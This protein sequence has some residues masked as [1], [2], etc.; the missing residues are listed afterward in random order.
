MEYDQKPKN[1]LLIQLPKHFPKQNG[2]I[3][4]LHICWPHRENC[5]VHKIFTVRLFF[6]HL[7]VLIQAHIGTTWKKMKLNLKHWE[8]SVFVSQK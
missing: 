7:Y 2:M 1:C 3:F 5:V 6:L 4:K 8:N